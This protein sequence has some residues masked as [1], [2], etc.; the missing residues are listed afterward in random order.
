MTLIA[1]DYEQKDHDRVRELCQRTDSGDYT[2]DAALVNTYASPHQGLT[3][4]RHFAAKGL[5]TWLAYGGCSFT[6]SHR[7]DQTTTKS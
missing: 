2:Y 1:I 5:D 3:S 6:H 7:R 4:S